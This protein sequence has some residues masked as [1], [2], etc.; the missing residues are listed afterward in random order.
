VLYTHPTAS[1]AD[2][3]A[4]APSAAGHLL[5]QLLSDIPQLMA[6]SPHTSLAHPAI[7]QY[8]SERLVAKFIKK[9]RLMVP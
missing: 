8:E 3:L 5:L 1:N 9:V 4:L 7:A 6:T 2:A